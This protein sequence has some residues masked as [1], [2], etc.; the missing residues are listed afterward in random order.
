M[1]T[2]CT[3]AP[4]RLKILNALSQKTDKTPNQI[5]S[6]SENSDL[7]MQFFTLVI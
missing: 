6:T 3:T 5:A 4:T 2:K 7:F 1:A